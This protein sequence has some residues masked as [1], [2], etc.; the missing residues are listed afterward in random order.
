MLCPKCGENVDGAAK[1]CTECG[2]LLHPKPDFEKQTAYRRETFEQG[3]G[4]VPD[5]THPLPMSDHGPGVPPHPGEAHSS[6]AAGAA[7]AGGAGDAKRPSASTATSSASAASDAAKQAQRAKERKSS[8]TGCIFGIIAAVVVILLLSVSCSVLNRCA[9]DDSGITTFGNASNT[10]NTANTASQTSSSLTSAA[11]DSKDTWTVLFY[12]CG[13]N[14][15]SEEGLATFNLQELASTTL[16]DKVTFVIEA[17]GSRSWRNTTIDP[18][19]LTRYTISSKGFYEQQK[20]P[21]ASMAAAST[22]ADFVSWGVENY[23][24]D[25]YMLVLWDHG[26]GS[27]Y[28]VCNDELYPYKSGFE[29]DTLTLT[30]IKSG[31]DKAGAQFDVIGFDTCLMATYETAAILAPYADYLVASEEVEPGS[32]WDY[33]SWPRWLG[34]HTGA[35]GAQLGA[36]ICDTYYSKCK[37]YRSADMATLSVVDLSKIDALSESFYGASSEIATATGD[38]KTLRALYNASLKATCFGGDTSYNM[39]DLGDLMSKA[40]SVVS[41]YYDDV[42]ADVEDAVV[43]QVHGRSHPNVTGLSVFYPLDTSYKSEFY[44]FLDVAG[45][46]PYAQFAAVMFGQYNAVDWSKYASSVVPSKAPVVAE[47]I[48][49][50]Y[51]ERINE[52]GQL[53]LTVTKG[54]DDIAEVAIELSLFLPDDRSIVY[55]GTDYDVNADW[56]AGVFADDFYGSWMAIDGNWVSATLY[57]VGDGYNMYYIP[58]LLNGEASNLI[59]RYDFD[60]DA[61]EVVCA[62]AVIDEANLAPKEMRALE[63]GDVVQF[64]FNGY[65]LDGDESVVFSL[66]EV[67]WSDDVVMDDIDLGD[68]AYLFRFVLTDVLGGEHPTDLYVQNYQ[69]GTIIVETLGEYLNEIGFSM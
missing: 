11:V 53:E 61:Y 43:Y 50:E 55:L 30:E 48:S 41:E 10:A 6:S 52:E 40:R 47:G 42:I 23:P 25:H 64:Q 4:P 34:A 27:V 8:K 7:S 20:L 57:E 39:V 36:Q 16:G 69:N 1:F 26:G 45:N 28:G 18:R 31:L 13:S 32:G 44:D 51:T 21:S 35:T 59:A 66:G 37:L 56:D 63:D 22:F 17:G 65:K 9:S 3:P 14:L 38:R 58:V 60:E 62:C 24:A 49:I 29:S 12:L 33:V 5:P 68:G 19:Y 15:E 54:L 67:T 46:I 2:A